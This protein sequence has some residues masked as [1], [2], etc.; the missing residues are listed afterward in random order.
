MRKS[1]MLAAMPALLLVVCLPSTASALS[2]TFAPSTSTGTVGDSFTVDVVV[3]GLIDG[4]AVGTYDLDITFDDAVVSGESIAVG[5]GLGAP[6]LS[7]EFDAFSGGVAD[8]SET[9]LIVDFASLKALQGDGFTLATLTFRGK[10]S[11]SSGLAFSQQLFGD[12]NGDAM[13]VAAES[14]SI[15]VEGAGTLPGVPE[16][17]TLLLMLTGGVLATT[18]RRTHRT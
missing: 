18:R 10:A 17:A 15:Q 7:I 16:P 9:S 5:P 2:L 8:I 3:S 14:G 13:A 12:Q 4:E 6:T 1:L 11:G